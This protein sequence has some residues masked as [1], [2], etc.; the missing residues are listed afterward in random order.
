[1]TALHHKMHVGK[2]ILSQNSSFKFQVSSSRAMGIPVQIQ[3]IANCLPLPAFWRLKTASFSTAVRLD[4]LVL[5]LK[6]YK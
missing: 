3:P 2:I 6:Y 4:T 5:E 1:M